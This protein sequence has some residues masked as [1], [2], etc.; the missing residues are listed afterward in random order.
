MNGPSPVDEAKISSRPH[1]NSV[2]TMGI[3]HHIFRFQRNTNS[4]PR[5][6]AFAPSLLNHCF[7]DFLCPIGFISL[8]L[9]P[10]PHKWGGVGGGADDSEY[11]SPNPSPLAERGTKPERQTEVCRTP[12]S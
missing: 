8:S 5:T 6:P 4:P 9:L 11:L 12:T 3:S 2:I 7:I 10:P 1:S